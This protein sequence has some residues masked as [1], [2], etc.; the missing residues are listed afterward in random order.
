M[1]HNRAGDE[2]SPL[3]ND[4]IEGVRQAHIVRARTRVDR[5]SARQPVGIVRATFTRDE[6]IL[7]FATLDAETEARIRAEYK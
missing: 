5:V 1:S 4:E 6:L 7:L 3:S 2:Y